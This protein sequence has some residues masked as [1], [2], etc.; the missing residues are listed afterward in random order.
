M[1]RLLREEIPHG[2]GVEITAFKDRE[3][4]NMMDGNSARKNEKETDF[5]RIINDPF[6]N[7]LMKNTV[8]SYREIPLNPGRIIFLPTLMKTAMSN[9]RKR[10]I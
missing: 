6:F 1:E 8:V 7:P 10:I 5:A 9:L 2:T 4:K 3:N